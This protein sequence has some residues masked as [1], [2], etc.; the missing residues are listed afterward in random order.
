MHIFLQAGFLNTKSAWE[1][2][3]HPPL[4]SSISSFLF[5][6]GFSATLHH[7]VNQEVHDGLVLPVE[8]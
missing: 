8:T 1:L 7:H 4:V 5:L 3:P 6:P 2:R